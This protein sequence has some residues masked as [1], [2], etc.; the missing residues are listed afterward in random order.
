[1]IVLA[2]QDFVLCQLPNYRWPRHRSRTVR[3]GQAQYPY[4]QEPVIN[5]LSH[6]MECAR[7]I[8]LIT[9]NHHFFPPSRPFSSA[10]QMEPLQHITETISDFYSFEA[11]S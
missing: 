9:L 11:P 3:M 5:D 2:P 10:T 6:L 8:T 7:I 4:R 1:M